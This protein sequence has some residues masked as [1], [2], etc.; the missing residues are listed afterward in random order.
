LK[1]LARFDWGV[2]SDRV[3]DYLVLYQTLQGL[4]L[5]E[6]ESGPARSMHPAEGRS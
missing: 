3:F 5:A 2:L 4:A 6:A 1:P